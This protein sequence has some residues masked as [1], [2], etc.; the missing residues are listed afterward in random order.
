MLAAV[1]KRAIQSAMHMVETV[2]SKLAA[3]QR[4]PAAWFLQVAQ[5]VLLVLLVHSYDRRASLP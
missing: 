1:N 3:V 4:T 2:L 5:Q